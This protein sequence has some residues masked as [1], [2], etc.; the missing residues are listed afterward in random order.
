LLEHHWDTHP[1]TSGG[2]LGVYLSLQ[3]EALDETPQGTAKETPG[4]PNQRDTN[5]GE[6]R[7][8]GKGVGA[9]RKGKGYTSQTY[10]PTYKPNPL[11]VAV[12]VGEASEKEITQ[13]AGNGSGL[14]SVPESLDSH[15]SPLSWDLMIITM[16]YCVPGAW[17]QSQAEAYI[18]SLG[19][20]LGGDSLSQ[21]P[22]SAEETN[23]RQ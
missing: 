9:G 2:T 13:R 12:V 19:R 15:T 22:R 4:A 20:P 16:A 5:G 6:D 7:T 23:S 8:P 18:E 1:A 17:V 21:C 11:V 10:S 14:N 3:G